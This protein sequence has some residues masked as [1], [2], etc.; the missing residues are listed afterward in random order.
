MVQASDA[1][2]LTGSLRDPRVL[3]YYRDGINAI[4]LGV[5]GECQYALAYVGKLKS[6]VFR[7]KASEVGTYGG[8]RWE[9]SS[10]H[11]GNCAGHGNEIM[12][13]LA[14]KIAELPSSVY[15]LIQYEG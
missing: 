7:R 3:D 5:I 15:Q 4:N 11:P 1:K 14:A 9:C 13:A 12:D 8:W 2:E 10:T 6:D